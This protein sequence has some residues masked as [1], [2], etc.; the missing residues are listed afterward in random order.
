MKWSIVSLSLLIS[1]LLMGCACKIPNT[2]SVTSLIRKQSVS[3]LSLFIEEQC[4][5]SIDAD[6]EL[7]WQRYGHHKV[8]S[9]TLQ[10]QSPASVRLAV[11]DPLGRPQILFVAD[12]QRFTFADN[13]QAEGY[14]GPLDSPF[15]S[16]YV[17]AFIVEKEFFGW[18]GGRV[19]KLPLEKV[20]VTRDDEFI[21]YEYQDAVGLVHWLGFDENHLRRHFL[22]DVD[23]TLLLEVLYGDYVLFGERCSWPGTVTIAGGTLPVEL[24]FR[25]K[26]I[27]GGVP[28]D[29]TLF[30]LPLPPSFRVHVVD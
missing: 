18:L 2:R 19:G 10:A 27:Y 22:F 7:S 16:R 28:L 23:K 12:G 21:W 8:F 5:E 13:R 25:I 11:V 17:P 6:L 14:T 20:D 9:A 15:I 24:G 26:K 29:S 1:L 3:R 4:T 30:T